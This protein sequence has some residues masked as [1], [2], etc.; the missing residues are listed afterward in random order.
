[1]KNSRYIIACFNITP[2]FFNGY[3]FPKSKGGGVFGIKYKKS[4]SRNRHLFR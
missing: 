2:E 4:K 1:M 3:A